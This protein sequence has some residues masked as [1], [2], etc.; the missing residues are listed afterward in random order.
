MLFLFLSYPSSSSKHNSSLD[1]SEVHCSNAFNSNT[2]KLHCTRRTN[3]RLG[4]SRTAVRQV[5]LYH[6]IHKLMFCSVRSNKDT[7]ADLV[8]SNVVC[9]CDVLDSE[10]RAMTMI[11]PKAF[12]R[13]LKYYHRDV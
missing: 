12:E 7:F 13:Q 1:Q 9:V 6:C 3:V 8:I 11:P 2:T 5:W 4:D 10:V